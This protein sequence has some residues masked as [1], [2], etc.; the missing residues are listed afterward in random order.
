[1]S[2]YNEEVLEIDFWGHLLNVC[3]YGIT[4]NLLYLL[5]RTFAEDMEA[6]E[7]HQIVITSIDS[8]LCSTDK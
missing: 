8:I 2:T 3:L 4:K 1:M 6:I 7:S 5:N